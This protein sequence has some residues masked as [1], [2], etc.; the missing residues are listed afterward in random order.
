M[1]VPFLTW[2]NVQMHQ[3]VAT[4][5]GMGFPIAAGGL[6]GYA[7]SGAA[8]DGLPTGSL[9]YIYLPA[10]LILA[11]GS[12]VTAPLGA[13][14]AHAMDVASLKKVFAYLLFGLAGYMLTRAF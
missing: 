10:L 8:L 4:S 3:A 13:K 7:V 1:T 5:A 12:V 2:C 11:I 6:I 14:V 9:G